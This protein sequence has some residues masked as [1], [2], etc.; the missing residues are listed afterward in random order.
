[1]NTRIFRILAIGVLVSLLTANICDART[2]IKKRIP[3]TNEYVSIDE[4]HKLGLTMKDLWH[5]D[6]MA[7]SGVIEAP[8]S[9]LYQRISAIEHFESKNYLRWYSKTIEPIVDNYVVVAIEHPIIAEGEWTRVKFYFD[10]KYVERIVVEGI[11]ETT[12][13]HIKSGEFE[14]VVIPKKTAIF[15]STIYTKDSEGNRYSFSEN[16]RIIVVAPNK[17][18]R[19]MEKSYTID[20]KDHSKNKI[21]YQRFLDEIAGDVPDPNWGVVSHNAKMVELFKNSAKVPETDIILQQRTEIFDNYNSSLKDNPIKP[22]HMLFVPEHQVIARGNSTRVKFLFN[23]RDFERIEIEKVGESSIEDIKKGEYIATIKP[24]KTTLF[25]C[26]YHGKGYKSRHSLKFRII[27][28]DPDKYDEVMR[29]VYI[30]RKLGGSDYREYLNELAG[31]VP[32]F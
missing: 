15:K 29:K 32:M 6:H 26:T 18:N 10:N 3:K 25:R 17:L 20:I 28:I 31:G 9:A 16:R 19:I 27:V 11:G 22:G 21:R 12:P 5:T 4:I 30:L 13:E 24:E 14:I 23:S 8:A 1:M 2:R 7:A